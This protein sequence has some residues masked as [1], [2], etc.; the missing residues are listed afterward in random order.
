MEYRETWDLS[1]IPDSEWNRENGRRNR[2]KAPAV[3]NINLKPCAGCGTALST[4][5]RR[6]PCPKCGTRND[7]RKRVPK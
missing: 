4:T 7:D 1:T 5:Q 3:T 2:A 6:Q